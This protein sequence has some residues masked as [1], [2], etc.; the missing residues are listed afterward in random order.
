MKD[1]WTTKDRKLLSERN[2]L[3]REIPR[4]KYTE[5]QRE[6]MKKKLVRIKEQIIEHQKSAPETKITYAFGSGKSRFV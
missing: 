2:R 4:T 3:E 6:A 5:K 1:A